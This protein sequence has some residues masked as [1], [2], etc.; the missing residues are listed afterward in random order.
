[1]FNVEQDLFFLSVVSYECMQCV[2]VGDPTNQAWICR[3]WNNS[4]SLNAT[5]KK[6]R[7]IRDQIVVYCELLHFKML[8]T[9]ATKSDSDLNCLFSS[10][11]AFL[12]FKQAWNIHLDRLLP[13]RLQTFSKLTWFPVKDCFQNVHVISPTVICYL[14]MTFDTFMLE[15]DCTELQSGTIHRAIWWL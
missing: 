15:R 14:H 8:K 9:T 2:T 7:R 6:K 4:V 12:L 10:C 11:S 13:D 3:Q 1:M 5:G